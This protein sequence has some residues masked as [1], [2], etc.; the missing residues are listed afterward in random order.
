MSSLERRLDNLEA[1]QPGGALMPKMVVTFVCPK[2]GITGARWLDGSTLKRAED[3][4]EAAFRQRMEARSAI[5]F[6]EPKYGGPAIDLS[7]MGMNL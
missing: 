7:D 1:R 3:E 4:A 2:R 5:V 6:A